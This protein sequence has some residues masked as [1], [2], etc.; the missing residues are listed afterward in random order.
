MKC[1]GGKKATRKKEMLVISGSGS[2]GKSTSIKLAYQSI[3][4]RALR[5]HTPL[6]AGYLYS[7]DREVAVYIDLPL[8]LGIATR[9]D[10]PTHVN[11]GLN[12]FSTNKC[13]MIV[14]ATRS[15][16]GSFQAAMNFAASH[17][18]VVTTIQK[19]KVSAVQQAGANSH[20][21]KQIH[22]WACQRLG[23]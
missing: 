16:G 13:Q 8:R 17:G 21:A 1:V 6:Q 4:T 5:K 11:D 18:F 15:R 3:I 9:G 14:C 7:T 19:M 23:I 2:C 20:M 12:F 22:A 10:S